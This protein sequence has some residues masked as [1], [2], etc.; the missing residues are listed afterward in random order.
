EGREIERLLGARRRKREEQDSE[1]LHDAALRSVRKAD[2]DR[3]I[4]AARG[5]T[6]PRVSDDGRGSDQE[7]GVSGER[8]GGGGVGGIRA[9]GGTRGAGGGRAVDGD[10]PRPRGDG[11]GR[12]QER[13]QGS[14]F[15]GARLPL[16]NRRCLAAS[17]HGGG[18]AGGHRGA[19]LGGGRR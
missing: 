5:P 8:G 18:R 19:A 6:S 9:M 2:G 1:S 7:D 4:E 14:P 11:R 15:L 10:D 16:R 3:P 17:L 12:R 13:G